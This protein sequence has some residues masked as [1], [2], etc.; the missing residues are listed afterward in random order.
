MQKHYLL[1]AFSVV[2][3]LAGAVI[4]AMEL[5][6]AFD[7]GTGLPVRGGSVSFLMS[8][9]SVAAMVAFAVFSMLFRGCMKEDLQYLSGENSTSTRVLMALSA[10]TLAAAAVYDFAANAGQL[11]LS[12]IILILLA[13]FS[14]LSIIV[15]ALR[16]GREYAVFS[17]VPIFWCCFWLVL[18]YRVRSIDPVITDY[19]YELFAVVAC[20]LFFSKSAGYDFGSRKFRLNVFFMSA[21]VYLCMV[22]A[23]GPLSAKLLYGVQITAGYTLLYFV[24]CCMNALGCMIWF[25]DPANR[26]FARSAA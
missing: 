14:A 10:L 22:T 1:P 5:G 16:P 23:A 13:A 8:L 2:S 19:V 12:R 24:A 11:P 15:R 18:I 6:R 26:D 4:R 25:L 3:G 20:A 7:P 17:L 21:A 9:F